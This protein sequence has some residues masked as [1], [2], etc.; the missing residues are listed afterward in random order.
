M[1]SLGGP[2]P[3]HSSLCVELDKNNKVWMEMIKISEAKLSQEINMFRK[4][5][6]LWDG[7]DGMG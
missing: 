4:S 1:V 6:L 3:V 2:N 5:Y 7:M